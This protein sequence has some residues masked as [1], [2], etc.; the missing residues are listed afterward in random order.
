MS[1][2][3]YLEIEKGD[4]LV[5]PSEQSSSLETPPH[6]EN[7]TPSSS[8]PSSKKFFIYSFLLLLIVAL[9][10]FFEHI[11]N[12]FIEILRQN[13]TLYSYYLS[14][15]SEIANNTLEGLSYMAIMGSIFF[16]M[17]PSEALF[18]YYLN[19]T[20][21]FVLVILLILVVGNLVGMILNYGFGRLVGEKVTKKLFKKLFP[22]YK[23]FVETYGKWVLIIG[24]IIPGPIEVLAVFY[25]SFKFNF[26]QYCIYVFIGRLI[27]FFLL[28]IAF[29]FFWDQIMLWQSSLLEQAV[30][31]GELY[32]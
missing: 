8:K 12:F 20:Q 27:K 25:G 19:S 16:L 17:L 30:V 5:L 26:K 13:P 14:I 18:L 23:R 31:L 21:H 2:E 4:K 29:V 7:L 32:S 15:K 28:F 6:I 10:F 1:K 11:S 9:Y 22:K 24:N 3:Y